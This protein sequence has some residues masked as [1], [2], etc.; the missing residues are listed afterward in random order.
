[1]FILMSTILSTKIRW[2]TVNEKQLEECYCKLKILFE[3][4]IYIFIY[5]ILHLC[6]FMGLSVMFISM[7]TAGEVSLKNMVRFNVSFIVK[8][9]I[10]LQPYRLLSRGSSALLKGLSWGRSLNS[11]W[12][13]SAPRKWWINKMY[14]TQTNFLAFLEYILHISLFLCP[15]QTFDACFQENNIYE[16]IFSSINWNNL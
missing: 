9:L 7:L 16:N 8:L 6:L 3:M 12:T 4:E 1:M 11:I 10:T 15:S 2:I 13:N 14:F 5:L